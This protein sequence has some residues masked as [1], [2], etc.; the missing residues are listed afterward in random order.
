MIRVSEIPPWVIFHIPHDS[1]T[2][3][4][5]LRD[6]FILNDDD[7]SHEL[8]QMTD[9]FTYDLIAQ[10]IPDIQIIR[11]PVSRLVVDVERFESDEEEP[12]AAR[13]MGVIYEVTHQL[14]QMRRTLSLVKREHLLS[15]WYRT[16]HDLLTDSVNKTLENHGRALIIDFHSFPS[17]ALPYETDLTAYRPEICIGTDSFHTPNEVVVELTNYFELHGF[18][19]GVNTPFSGSIVPALHYKKDNR[20]QTLM[21]EIRR[22]LYLNESTSK[23]NEKFAR[24]KEN[25]QNILIACLS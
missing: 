10:N 16:H 25:L 18:K 21:I 2:I 22:D 6:Q 14:K 9:H 19:V 17:V 8:G 12:M 7:L 20:V 15:T 1:T 11:F 24:L 13:G 23:L 3:P 4:P 5:E